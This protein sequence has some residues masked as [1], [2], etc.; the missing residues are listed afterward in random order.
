MHIEVSIVWHEISMIHWPFEFS[1]LLLG[2]NSCEVL[3]KSA[4]NKLKLPCS[5]KILKYGE[6]PLQKSISKLSENEAEIHSRRN[7]HMI[8]LELCSILNKTL[9]DPL[10]VSN[11][12]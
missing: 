5:I 4:V 11:D 7:Q 9:G 2:F 10:P 1:F 3:V 8:G 12:F 6:S